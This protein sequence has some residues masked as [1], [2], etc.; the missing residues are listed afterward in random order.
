MPAVFGG[1]PRMVFGSYRVVVVDA[2][3]GGVGGRRRGHLALR[4]GAGR[5]GE[6]AA[7]AARHKGK[8]NRKMYQSSRHV[9]SQGCYDSRLIITRPR[10]LSIRNRTDT[11]AGYVR[12]GSLMPP[13]AI[14]PL[15]RPDSSRRPS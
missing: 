7:P 10:L 3:P 9:L 6:Y 13:G 1:V 2:G 14:K 8:D 5:G 15:G 11:P 12:T 4:V